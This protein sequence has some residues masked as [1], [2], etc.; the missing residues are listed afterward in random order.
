M[1]ILSN[2]NG[3]IITQATKDIAVTVEA[4]AVAVVAE[5]VGFVGNNAEFVTVRHPVVFGRGRSLPGAAA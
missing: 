2:R 5:R 1:E 4:Q 3:R